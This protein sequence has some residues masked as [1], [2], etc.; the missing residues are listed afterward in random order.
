[1]PVV[2]K[3]GS[4]EGVLLFETEP[5]EA[6]LTEIGLFE[7]A[8]DIVKDSAATSESVV[9][10]IRLYT[11]QLLAAIDDLAMEKRDGGSLSSARLELGIKITAEGNII[12]A[13]GTAEANLSIAL[14]WDFS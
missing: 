9:S 8:K 10:T 3:V 13:K 7:R 1:M 5:T 11:Q 2:V 4:P 6:D 14:T 12:V